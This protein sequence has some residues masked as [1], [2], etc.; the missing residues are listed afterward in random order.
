MP[1]F[2]AIGR[3]G[4]LKPTEA[5]IRTNTFVVPKAFI[6]RYRQRLRWF[7]GFDV[8]IGDERF[9]NRKIDLENRIGGVALRNHFRFG[10]LLKL[11]IVDGSTLR[12]RTA[13]ET[14]IGSATYD[15]EDDTHA[16][17]VASVNPA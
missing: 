5:Q 13:E 7:H 15:G 10:Q 8:V 2:S 16:D 3:S 1:Q 17:D 6:N 12:I 11:E 4:F 14:E 9:P